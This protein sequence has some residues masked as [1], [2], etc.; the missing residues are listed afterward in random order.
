MRRILLRMLVVWLAAL[1]SPLVAQDDLVMGQIRSPILTIDPDRLFAESHFGQ[2][3][4]AQVLAQTEALGVENRRIE[5]A[6]TEEE[7]S[8]TLRRPTMPVETFRA[9]AGAFDVKVQGIRQAQDAKERDLQQGLVRGR[10]AFLVAATPVLG[11][12]MADS[13]AAVILDRRSVFLRVAL[14]DITEEAIAAID[15][16][17]GDGSALAPEGQTPP[18]DQPA[19]QP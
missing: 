2:R 14:V 16:A 8:L 10:D 15:A 5:A 13:G 11:Q 18:E 12:M 4:N 7:R 1:A 17:I 6:L 3:I 19:T 9:E